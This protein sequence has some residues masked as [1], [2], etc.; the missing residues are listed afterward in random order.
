MSWVAV[1]VLCGICYLQKLVGMVVPP[2][3]LAAHPALARLSGRL[4][5]ALLAALVVTGALAT[6]DHLVPDARLVGV[7]AAVALLSVR[8]PLVVVVVGAAAV[9]A[10]VRSVG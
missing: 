10:V 7:A 4:P 2:G 5:A 3:V 6:G 1:G 9:T 8:A